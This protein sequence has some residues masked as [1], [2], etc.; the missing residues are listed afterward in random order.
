[1]NAFDKRSSWV[2]YK[3]ANERVTFRQGATGPAQEER[4]D[5][6]RRSGW[7]CLWER[8]AVISGRGERVR[9]PRR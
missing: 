7:R 6:Q 2:A 9:R 8:D 4:A 3:R 1:M 5:T